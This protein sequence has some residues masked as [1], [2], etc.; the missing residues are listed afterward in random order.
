MIL[1]P[2][3]SLLGS[4][5]RTGRKPG[6]TA[7]ALAALFLSALCGHALE[8]QNEGGT[9]RG[10]CSNI[11]GATEVRLDWRGQNLAG[12]KVELVSTRSKIHRVGSDCMT[13]YYKDLPPEVPR[14]WTILSQPAEAN[15]QVVASGNSA[16]L[17]LPLAGN[18]TVQLT[19]CPSGN[20]PVIESPGLTNTFPL[21]T[22]SGTITIRADAELPLRVQERPVLPPSALR[23]TPRLDLTDEERSCRCQGGGGLINPQWV[24]VNPWTGPND[25]KL[26]EGYVVRSWPPMTDAPFN[27]DLAWN[28]GDWY[29]IHDV[30]VVVSP[31]PKYYNLVSTKPEWEASPNLLGCETQGDKI[32][33]HLRP[34][35]GDRVSLFGFWILDCGH[36]PF[37]TEIH[38]IVGWAM[39]R[40]RPV[41]I[42]NDATFAF[43]LVTNTVTAPA[44]S[45]L[46]VPGIATD[47][48]FNADTGENTG[49]GNNSL[50]Q[51]ARCNPDYAA[52]LLANP[53]HPER[54]LRYLDADNNIT[55]SPIQ[56]EY[57]FNIYL[58]KNPSDVFAEVGQRRP[59]APLHV[60]ISNP[61]ASD[62]PPPTYTREIETTNGVSFEYLRVHLDLRGFPFS[63]YSRRIEAAWVYPMADNW[64]LAQYRV[65]LSKLDVYDDLDSKARWPGSDG[66][67]ILWLMLPSANQ[68]WTRLLDGF[69]NTH[70]TMTF[71]PPWETGSSDS[72]FRR[73][74]LSV[75]PLHRLG[76]DILSFSP[77][78]NFWMGGYEADEGFDDD[79][80]RISSF[81]YNY[82]NSV[83]TTASS[84]NGAFAATFTST[85]IATLN[86]GTLSSAATALGRHYLI[87]CTN[88]INDRNPIRDSIAPLD[89]LGLLVE[90]ISGEPP[91]SP[92]DPREIYG[93]G[94][95]LLGDVNKDGF[96]DMALSAR[97]TNLEAH[98][99]LGGRNGFP[100][101]PHA[102]ASMPLP[103]A[104]GLSQQ[105]HSLIGAGDVNGDGV[106]DLLIGTPTYLNDQTTNGAAYLFSG[107]QL[108][109]GGTLDASNAIWS[110]KGG[111][112]NA[113]FG[114]SVAAGDINHDGLS[115]LVVSA[116]FYQNSIVFNR[117]VGRVF[118][119]LGSP[120][121]PGTIASQVVIPPT[122]TGSQHWFGFSV[123][124]AGDLNRDGYTDV[125]IGAPR[126]T[127]PE[128]NEGAY[129]IYYG[130][131]TGLVLNA[132]VVSEGNVANAQFGYAV[133]G[134]GDLDGDGY[135]DVLV[136]APFYGS[137]EFTI[138]EGY[139]AAIRGSIE[140][141]A[142][143]LWGKLGG[144]AGA[145][146][147]SD[148]SGIGD[149]NGDGLADVAIG[150]PDETHPDGLRGRV[151]F[152]LGARLLG[153]GIPTET[154]RTWGVSGVAKPPPAVSRASDINADG[155]D[156][157]LTFDPTGGGDPFARVQL[158][159]GRGQKAIVPTAE[160]FYRAGAGEPFAFPDIFTASFA[161]NMIRSGQTN[162][163]KLAVLLAQV[164]DLY[165]TSQQ[166]GGNP[167]GIVPLLQRLQVVVPTNLFN[168]YFS[169]V[170]LELG[171]AF[172]IDCGA[173]NEYTDALGRQWMPDA[174]Y[175]VTSNTYLATFAIGPITN[176]LLGDRYLPD[177]MLNSE[178]WF[179]GAIRY[180]VGVPNGWYTVL[181]YFSENYPLAASPALGG[182]GC[183][184][185]ARIFDVEVERQ[186]VNAYNQADAALPPNGDGLGRLYTATQIA[187]TVE[188]TDGLL[189]IAV[190]DRGAGNPPENAAIKGIAILGRPSPD[191]RFA[192]RPRIARTTRDG[193]QV[194]VFVDPQASLA[195]YLAGEIPLCL[196][197]SQDLALWQ[198]LPNLPE[199]AANGAFFSLSMPT[200]SPS[201]FRVVI[202]DESGTQ[203]LP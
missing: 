83:T 98:L 166:A 143:S 117:P 173:T 92:V 34:V 192:T 37:Y 28:G 138:Q 95:A 121:G 155:F 67:W 18:Y 187:F 36:E 120:G 135:D 133:A 46:Y 112:P 129:F 31:D 111:F 162:E 84:H 113:Q 108:G 124:S 196:Q 97:G 149:I 105:T 7:R 22:T 103:P 119:Y 73:P 12:C 134:A 5:L 56:R 75:D 65:S 176:A 141:I 169:D 79:P 125:I 156:D 118:V 21:I 164:K 43:D 35:E 114:Y 200:N 167:G 54:C 160:R 10:N 99:F 38:P 27:H 171:T 60:T 19:I 189:D 80:G 195:R 185:C 78:V 15:A 102:I 58:P 198:T 49:G 62:G 182:T 197:S 151:S 64:G 85:R 175:L 41:R 107:A 23:P 136:S 168:Q 201:F 203:R 188:I 122:V 170:D 91:W 116:P 50:A 146:F 47:L 193:G 87:T 150:A 25:Y 194:G 9:P 115:D 93:S 53:G 199:V 45:D 147:G 142:G 24:T 55:Q 76:S 69:N 126:Y 13:I 94:A 57:D 14:Q 127:Q 29:V 30:G 145:H 163:A 106:P 90:G 178:R 51:P 161:T 174:P 81:F 71:N 101:V 33:D 3:L 191:T 186:R 32:P 132:S 6:M 11:P 68:S 26:V 180:Q 154:W 190:F 177:T 184:T 123:A 139:V 100:P 104:P 40:N 1:L 202:P 63:T 72:V 17:T 165:L 148:L 74:P 48:W 59:R 39:H 82:T 44:G 20:C 52:C 61:H 153:T 16:T 88:R 157:T 179:D 181:L 109:A 110:V 140:G 42:P 96:P 130:S 77:Y 144:F 158:V 70:G 89:Q 86:N 2:G 152:F 4:F 172:Y 66:D 131:P 8:P 128:V 137:G 183:A 159:L